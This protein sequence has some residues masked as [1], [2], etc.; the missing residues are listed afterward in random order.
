MHNPDFFTLEI[1]ENAIKV[2]D[3]KIS[4]NEIEINKI[5]FLNNLPLSIFNQDTLDTYK[6]FSDIIK[7]LVYDLKINKK[8]VNIIIPDTY[9]YSQILKMPLL[10]EK[11]L[12]SAIKY[13]A[14]HFIPLPIEDIN[15]DL[16]IIHQNEK[17]K[18][19]LVLVAAVSKKLAQKI[20]EVLEFTGLIPIFLENQVSAFNRFINKFSFFISNNYSS[21]IFFI[22]LGQSSTSLYFFDKNNSIISKIHNFNL[23]YSLFLK[24][25]QI[26]TS[27]DDKKNYDI[28]KNFDLK[29]KGN[30]DVETIINPI[31]KQFIFEIKKMITPPAT[32]LFIGDIIQFPALIEILIKNIDI[33][34]FFSVLNPPY[35]LFKKNSQIENYK[36]KLPFFLTTLGG[37]IE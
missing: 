7:K 6:K 20:E 17:E 28:L 21:K 26:N 3:G 31:T 34:I 32:G 4:S 22:N 23:G 10:N 8:K 37:E 15:I 14:D 2:I 12:I 9:T 19:L 11:E 35:S 33:P 25:L 27:F 18:T 30:I 36:E 13:Q 29:N 16:E 5:S 1:N 24:E